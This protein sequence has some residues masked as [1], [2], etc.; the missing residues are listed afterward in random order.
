MQSGGLY[1]AHYYPPKGIP[2]LFN[3]DVMPRRFTVALSHT[4]TCL[5]RLISV[6]KDRW[7]VSLGRSMDVIARACEYFQ[8]QRLRL[9]MSNL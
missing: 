6:S 5:G 9:T 3:K 4:K 1:T 2:L 8:S 7:L